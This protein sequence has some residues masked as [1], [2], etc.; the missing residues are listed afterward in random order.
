MQ[1]GLGCERGGYVD[2][3]SRTFVT[4]SFHLGTLP[5]QRIRTHAL[6]GTGRRGTESGLGKGPH[7]SVPPP[8]ASPTPHTR[9]VLV[10]LRSMRS[11]HRAERDRP[12]H[13]HGRALR[14]PAAAGAVLRGLCARGRRRGA[15]PGVVGGPGPGCQFGVLQRSVDT[16]VCTSW[17][18]GSWACRAA[19]LQAPC[20]GQCPALV[21]LAAPAMF[22]L[23]C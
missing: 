17:D 18:G 13:G 16:L 8:N 11:P 22:C 20:V 7:V 23:P 5:M 21:V 2:E 10:M 1:Q 4:M 3:D 12:G 14:G 9:T 6:R 19:G 15:P